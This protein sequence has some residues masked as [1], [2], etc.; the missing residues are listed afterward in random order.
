ME[1]RRTAVYLIIGFSLLA[2]LATGRG[3]FF[4]VAYAFIGLLVFSFLWAWS[5]P[6]WLRLRRQTRARR[7]QVGSTLAEQFTVR[8][9]GLLPKLW[10]EIY[11]ESD[12][13]GHRASH[14]ISDLGPH[15][16]RSWQV[17][18][19]CV[20]RGAYRLGPLR[21]V[22]GDPFGLFEA[23][24]QIDATSPLV[25]YPATVD[26]AEFAVPVGSLSGGDAVRRRTHHVTTN[27]AGVRDYVPGDAFS[28]IHWPSTAR[29][30]RLIVK[31]FELD[32]LSDVWLMLDGDRTVHV[33]QYDPADPEV[34]R[35][36]TQEGPL[37][38]P[39][40]TEE[41]AVTVTASLARHFLERARAVGL[42]TDGA[43]H[44]VIQV[45]R[46]ARQLTKI[47][48]T[49]AV[50]QARGTTVFSH[51]LTSH[52]SHLPRGTTVVLITPSTRDGWIMAAHAYQ[53]RGLRVVVVL[54]D[55]R[56]FGGRPGT[57]EVA[58]RLG[59]MG[60]PT[61]VIRRGDDLRLALSQRRV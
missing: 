37:A 39:P 61:Y 51:V 60:I 2:G 26:V 8:N 14:V 9:A 5:G 4:T 35:L 15:R 23:E 41:Y 57:D 55:Q 59:T 53:R 22:T 29:K 24:R 6:N 27:A 13:P 34:A 56:T 25:V 46:G 11:D 47:L 50:I 32:P 38:V 54:I 20:Q 42:V 33:G 48:E 30:D 28:R 40:T 44:E 18:T 36:L 45:D 52:G 7:A 21:I 12:L 49:L 1:R 10:L 31:E 16:E 17:Q 58:L 43:R 3:F 19:L